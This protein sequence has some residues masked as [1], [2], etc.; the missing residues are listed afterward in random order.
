MRC[1]KIA[2]GRKGSGR[3]E[4]EWYRSIE[5]DARCAS[6]IRHRSSSI[7]RSFGF[8]FSRRGGG[9]STAAVFPA[10]ERQMYRH[11]SWL[12]IAW[13]KFSCRRNNAIRHRDSVK[14]NEENVF[15]RDR[16]YSSFGFTFR[17]PGLAMGDLVLLGIVQTINRRN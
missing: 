9:R 7:S 3:E 8:F 1:N 12:P 5:E 6:R 2:R 16:P 4:R 10:A 17:S 11:R 15:T 13:V 14:S